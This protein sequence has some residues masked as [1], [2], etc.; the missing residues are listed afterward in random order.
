[1][2]VEVMRLTGRQENKAAVKRFSTLLM[3]LKTLELIS[4]NG[5]IDFI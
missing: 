1:M 3:I 2:S 5:G 4:F